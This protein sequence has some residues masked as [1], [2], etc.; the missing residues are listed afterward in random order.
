MI[1]VVS[2]TCFYLYLCIQYSSIDIDVLDPGKLMNL[3]N[4]GGTAHV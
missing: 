2:V 1:I 4:S 3:G